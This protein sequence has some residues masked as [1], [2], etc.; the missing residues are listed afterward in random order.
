M[1]ADTNRSL[2]RVRHDCLV[3][4]VHAVHAIALPVVVLAQICLDARLRRP[5]LGGLGI[6]RQEVSHLHSNDCCRL[7]CSMFDMCLLVYVNTVEEVEGAIGR[8]R[9]LVAGRCHQLGEAVQYSASDTMLQR[10]SVGYAKTSAR[11]GRRW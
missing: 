5:G 8:S 11:C 9:E 4:P 3:L 10:W 6:R 1:S 2:G 7:V